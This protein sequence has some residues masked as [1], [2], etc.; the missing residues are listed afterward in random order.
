VSHGR[1]HLR[2]DSAV[3]GSSLIF[4]RGQ[5]PCLAAVPQFV[6]SSFLLGRVIFAAPSWRRLVAE[7]KD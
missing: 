2:F 5:V 6:S 1:E 7:L 4:V 3:V